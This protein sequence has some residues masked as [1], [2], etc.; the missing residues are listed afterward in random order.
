MVY[1]PSVRY[2]Y[3]DPYTLKYVRVKYICFSNLRDRLSDGKFNIDSIKYVIPT[4]L[5]N[6]KLKEY[7]SSIETFFAD[8]PYKYR[9]FKLEKKTTTKYIHLSL[10][11]KNM[12]FNRDLLYLTCFRYIQEFPEII[13]NFLLKSKNSKTIEDK[14]Y[15]FQKS[16]NEAII[17]NI[18]LKYDNLAGH[19]LMYKFDSFEPIL[20]KDFKINLK[21][22]N[23]RSVHAYFNN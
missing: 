11:V 19:G 7:L 15:H 8:K 3:R 18:Y 20:L 2:W 4:K 13:E 22:I 1:K 5:S 12:G 23:V 16:H 9:I 17:G 21:N 14:F 6:N 10:N